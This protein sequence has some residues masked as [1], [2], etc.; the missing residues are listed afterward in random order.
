MTYTKQQGCIAFIDEGK[1]TEKPKTMEK[2]GSQT[3]LLDSLERL[4]AE[5]DDFEKVGNQYF[6]DIR[7]MLEKKEKDDQ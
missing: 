1:N 7:I 4:Y 2:K 5:L 3:I 6:K